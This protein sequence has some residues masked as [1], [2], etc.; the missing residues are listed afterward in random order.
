VIT[1]NPRF[2]R[3][4]F[5]LVVFNTKGDWINSYP[6]KTYPPAGKNGYTPQGGSEKWRFNDNWRISCAGDDTVY[7]LSEDALRPVSI[8]SFGKN[9]HSYNQFVEPQTE[10]G[11][12]SI[13][14]MRET[15][16]FLYLKKEHLWKL[17]AYEWLPGQWGSSSYLNYSLLL[18]DKNQGQ[19]Y[20]LRFEDDLL[21]ILPLET[22]QMKQTWDELG[23]VYRI[24][25][26]MDVLEWIAEAKKNNTLPDA[27]RE[28][29]MELERSIDENSNPVMFIYKERSQKTMATNLEKYFRK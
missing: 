15:E 26:A 17:E 3:D 21:G 18:Y 28:R 22:I 9:Y 13:E 4:S 7:Q 19:S 25:H 16:R 1:G 6:R 14:I 29:V 5:Q 11:R 2:K 8:F 20:N 23:I 24:V 27:T 10:V 12:Y